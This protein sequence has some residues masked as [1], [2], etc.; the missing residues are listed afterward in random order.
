MPKWVVFDGVLVKSAFSCYKVTE[1]LLDD[2]DVCIAVN[3]PGAPAGI[4]PARVARR[5]FQAG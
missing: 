5:P 3:I 2:R 1:V 4:A